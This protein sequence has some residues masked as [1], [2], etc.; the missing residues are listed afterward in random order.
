MRAWTECQDWEAL[1]PEAEQYFDQ[2]VSEAIK[3]RL[4]KNL[5]FELIDLSVE[6]STT[7]QDKSI[8]KQRYRT[9]A[10]LIFENNHEKNK[11]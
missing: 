10:E 1:N 4:S 5:V 6:E 3:D 7:N 2:F 9:K 8:L 11:S